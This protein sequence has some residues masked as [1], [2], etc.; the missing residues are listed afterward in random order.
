VLRADVHADATVAG[1]AQRAGLPPQALTATVEEFTGWIR[2]GRSH[3]S[4]FGRPL[5]G[6]RPLE[7]PPFF[8]LQYFP[9]ARKVLGGVRTDLAARVL[10][11]DGAVVPGLYAAGEVAGMAG[12]HINGR[13]ALEGTMIGP[14]LLSGKIAGRTAAA[15]AAARP[16]VAG[17]AQ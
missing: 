10:R 14:S 13:A 8:A 12:G 16:W 7:A 6:L 15:D 4:R 3:D 2:D 1:L 17:E 9:L 5:A 11:K